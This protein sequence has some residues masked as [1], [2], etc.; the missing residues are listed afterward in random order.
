MKIADLYF[1][2]PVGQYD[3]VIQYQ[4]TRPSTA[5]EKLILTL[6]IQ[7]PQLIAHGTFYDLIQK[8]KIDFELLTATLLQL[9]NYQMI[10]RFTVDDELM[11]KPLNLLEATTAGKKLFHEKKIPLATTSAKEEFWLNL[12]T[13][14]ITVKKP[15]GLKGQNILDHSHIQLEKKDLFAEK[16]HPEDIILNF[17]SQAENE[18]FKWK[19]QN[20]SLEKAI[21]EREDFPWFSLPAIVKIDNNGQ[22]SLNSPYHPLQQMFDRTDQQSIWH[23]WI[24]PLFPSNNEPLQVKNKLNWSQVHA[25]KPLGEIVSISDPKITVLDQTFWEQLIKEDKILPQRFYLVISHLYS[26]PKVQ[27]RTLFVPAKDFDCKE[28]VFFMQISQKMQA[29]QWL[30]A[31]FTVEFAGEQKTITAQLALEASHLWALVKHILEQ[32]QSLS[33]IAFC[34]LFQKRDQLFSRLPQQLTL[35]DM[36]SF[37]STIK[38]ADIIFSPE[39]TKKIITRILPLTEID[40]IKKFNLLFS[41]QE[42]P[43]NLIAIQLKAK[44]LDSLLTKNDIKGTKSEYDSVLNKTRNLIQNTKQVISLDVLKISHDSQILDLTKVNYTKLSDILEKWH[45]Q[46]QSI[47]KADPEI[48]QYSHDFS[49]FLQY[50]ASIDSMFQQNF[51]LQRSEPQKTYVVDTNYLMNHP[52]TLKMQTDSLILIPDIVVKE[53]DHLKKPV[54]SEDKKLNERAAKARKASNLL[55]ELQESERVK[56]V[57]THGKLLNQ[58]LGKLSNDELIL[59]VAL[60]ERFNH[61]VLVTGDRNLQLLA[62]KH[63][64]KSINKLS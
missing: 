16:T 46:I 17:I 59:S 3:T 45:E 13:H 51:A 31:S 12:L 61:A 42:V 32:H 54:N 14:E 34:A 22:L 48:L 43:L 40:E 21:I 19:N 49:L 47:I 62:S 58:A 55:V 56:I 53:L 23:K 38:Q 25:V 41:Q 35:P 6:I 63:Q 20:I 60:Y 30:N 15:Q 44:L 11:H 10:N 4:P 57:D 8:L 2:C 29:F 26:E 39:Q 7:H 18:T 64:I 36:Y 50:L 37:Y 1:S 24:A 33:V 5:L 52:Q 9:Q 28:T 27:D